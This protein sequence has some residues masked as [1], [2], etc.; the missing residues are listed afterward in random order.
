MLSPAV[1]HYSLLHCMLLLICREV[2][3]LAEC[4]QS[5]GKL[6]NALNAAVKKELANYTRLLAELHDMAQ[7]PLQ[8]PGEHTVHAD[9]ELAA[10][11]SCVPAPP[12]SAVVSD[13]WCVLISSWL[14]Q[15]SLL[16]AARAA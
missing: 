15:V 12:A 5:L 10:P 3:S 11:P 8:V 14:T 4:Q 13:V 6:S 2:R 7:A 9:V 16:N 1:W